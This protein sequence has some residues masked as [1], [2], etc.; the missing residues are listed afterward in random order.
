MET[1]GKHYAGV[2]DSK[3][4]EALPQKRRTRSNV[5]VDERSYSPLMGGEAHPGLAHKRHEVVKDILEERQSTDSHARTL[6]MKYPRRFETSLSTTLHPM[7][8]G[9][10]RCKSQRPDRSFS[11][12][13]AQRQWCRETWRSSDSLR[14]LSRGN[15]W[16]VTSTE[17]KDV[18]ELHPGA[19]PQVPRRTS[20]MDVRDVMNSKS[21]GKYEY[22]AILQQRRMSFEAHD[23]I[24]PE[25]V[26]QNIF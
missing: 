22:F 25:K 15:A 1:N 12:S 14:I 8:M 9:T 24:R 6:L 7:A 23:M 18:A 20:D 2:E 5:G 10:R 16:R 17:R 19:P 21:P 4:S 26:A 13:N 3:S 11:T